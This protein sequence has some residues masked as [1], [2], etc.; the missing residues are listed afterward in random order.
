[1]TAAELL[2]RLAEICDLRRENDELRDENRILRQK[3]R[4]L[5]ELVQH[6]IA[7]AV[8]E[9]IGEEPGGAEI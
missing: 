3:V 6:R 9:G 8:D 1:V 7:H 5:S 2:E 4:Q